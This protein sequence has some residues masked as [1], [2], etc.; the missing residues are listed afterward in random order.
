MHVRKCSKACIPRQSCVT[1]YPLCETALWYSVTN[2]SSNLVNISYIL[3]FLFNAYFTYIF[4]HV[5]ATGVQWFCVTNF[6][7]WIE[8][9]HNCA[10]KNENV[11]NFWLIICIFFLYSHKYNY[12]ILVKKISLASIEKNCNPSQWL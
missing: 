3:L 2:C 9:S 1:V 4:F 10:N 8:L 7:T 5:F 6:F 12:L 11:F